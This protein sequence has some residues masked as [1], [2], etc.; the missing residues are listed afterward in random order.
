[1]QK[2]SRFFKNL[3][4]LACAGICIWCAADSFQR[5]ASQQGGDAL[6]FAA[7]MRV[8][9]A[10]E[11]QPGDTPAPSAPPA[12]PVWTRDGLLAESGGE[13][14]IPDDGIV[15]FHSDLLPGAAITP[16]PGR[17][18]GP[19][20]E[21]ALEGGA[22]VGSFFVRDSTGSGTDLA[23]ELLEEP[24]VHIK[25]DGSV[26]VLIYHT[27]TSEAYALSAPGFYYTD[28]E[29]RTQNQDRSVVAAGEELAKAL[30]ARGI[31]VV[32]D[33]TVNDGVYNGSYDRSWEVIQN[34]LAKYPGIQV[35]IDLHRDSMTTDAGVKYKPTAEIGGRKAAQ[36]MMIAGCDADGSWGDFPDWR[37]NLRWMLRVQETA[38]AMYPGLMR[39]LNFSNSKYNMNATHG[40]MLIEI[41]TEVN[42]VPEARYTGRLV[43]EILAETLKKC[44]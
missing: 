38:Q 13:G 6:L 42:T 15:P 43:G 9:P 35:T 30:E 17:A 19:V 32:H 31:G 10:E 20:E 1:M 22:Q 21:I 41:G 26:E 12:A 24:D 40:S 29:T 16:E 37:Q 34:N 28:M 44:A 11:A 5:W 7:G 33:K 27:H 2:L 8:S 4:T 14:G 39:P 3:V 25:S 18:N 23:A 36:A